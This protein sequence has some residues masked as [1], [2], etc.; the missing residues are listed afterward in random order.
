VLGLQ[1]LHTRLVGL[2]CRSILLRREQP[3]FH[4]ELFTYPWLEN[5]PPDATTLTLRDQTAYDFRFVD[6]TPAPHARPHPRYHTAYPISTLAA[7][8]AQLIQ[9]GTLFGSARL[10]LTSTDTAQH[11]RRSAS[12]WRSPT[13]ICAARPWQPRMRSAAQTH[14]SLRTS[15]SLMARSSRCRRR[16]YASRGTASSRAHA[17]G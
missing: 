8:D 4:H 17:R 7:S 3:L 9:L 12:A 13:R 6:Y 5:P 10:H 2:A 16:P 1:R 15:A 14:S 11:A